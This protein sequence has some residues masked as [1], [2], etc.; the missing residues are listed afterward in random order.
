[1][2]KFSTFQKLKNVDFSANFVCIQ[3]GL[4]GEIDQ[5]GVYGGVYACVYLCKKREKQRQ[6][7]DADLF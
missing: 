7:K 4:S 5:Q 6:D 3:L 1:M 2:F